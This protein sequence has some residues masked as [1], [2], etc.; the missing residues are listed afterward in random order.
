MDWIEDA[1]AP[2]YDTV[3]LECYEPNEGARRFYERRGYRV[4]SSRFN[5]KAGVE[6]LLMRKELT[7]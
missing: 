2:K 7:K 1:A 4:V 6:D 5:E 3:E